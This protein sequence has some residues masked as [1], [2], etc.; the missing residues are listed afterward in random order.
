MHAKGVHF[1]FV[2]NSPWELWPVIR[3]FMEEAGFPSGSCTLKEYGGAGSA[4]AK[5]WEEPGQRKRANVEVFLK[6]FPTSKF[7]LVGDSGEQDMQLYTSLAAQYPRNVLGIFI[8]DVTTTLPLG[9]S[10]SAATSGTP[11]GSSFPP[12][13][14]EWN[15]VNS[16]NDLAGLIE[17]ERER[18]AETTGR[19]GS[20]DTP[21]H[22]PPQLPPRPTLGP[23]S[24]SS[25]QT[26]NIA[27]SQT[28]TPSSSKDDTD[29]ILL[30]DLDA[31]ALSP[32][33]PIRSST[34]GPGPGAKLTAEQALVE[35]FYR[36][37]A[38]CERLLPQHIPLRIFR[39]GGEV[40]ECSGSED[41]R[42]SE[43][44][45]RVARVDSSRGTRPHRDSF[46][47]ERPRALTGIVAYV[48][49]RRCFL[50]VTTGVCATFSRVSD[51]VPGEMRDQS[52]Q[53]RSG[54]Q[55]HLRRPGSGR[56]VSS[57]PA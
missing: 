22:T 41:R 37:V 51:A 35:G 18:N 10:P 50:I 54:D 6:E 15:H 5:L 4:I 14:V 31:D 48:R 16:A 38:E 11:K 34:I 53:Y 47:A 12:P 55:L 23:R 56:R 40:G 21:T 28:A 8:R 25:S 2:S 52:S 36:K 13:A 19:A 57:D 20:D 29:P 49:E 17:E 46:A 3:N 32:N 42:G 43:A 45:A 44:D 26:I 39:H 9:A 24:Q 33:N 7:L 30:S 27:K 1:H